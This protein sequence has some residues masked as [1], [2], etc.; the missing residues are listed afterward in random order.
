[1][2]DALHDCP[3]AGQLHTDFIDRRHLADWVLE[4]PGV[5]LWVRNAVGVPWKAG[6]RSATGVIRAKH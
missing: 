3:N 6:T 2:R 4:H 1:M 5:L